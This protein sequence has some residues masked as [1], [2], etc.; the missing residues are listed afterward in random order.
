MKREAPLSGRAYSVLTLKAVD[1]EQRIIRG[2]AT[3]PTPDRMGDIVEP[4]GV[5]Y[6][7]P[8]PLLHQHNSREP[9]GTVKFDKPTKDG[10]DF[11][12]RLA[13]VDEPPSLKER[14]DVAWSEVKAGLVRAVSIGF[15]PIEMSFLD[16][17]GIRFLKSEV[18]ELSLVTIPANQDAT[19]SVIRSVDASMLAASGR[20]QEDDVQAAAELVRAAS[21]RS[22]HVVKLNHTRVRAKPFIIRSVKRN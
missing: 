22:V 15:K 9:V 10:I 4:L 21:G 3:T 20:E 17:G 13:R 16:D 7:N 18:L 6:R 19:I 14:I 1:E 2:T 5:S 11:E 8:L 12:A